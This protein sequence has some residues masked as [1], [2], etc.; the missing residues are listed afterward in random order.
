MFSIDSNYRFQYETRIVKAKNEMT[1]NLSNK[2]TGEGYGC[3]TRGFGGSSNIKKC[4][5][6]C[7]GDT[8]NI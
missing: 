6:G 4:G 1:R 3:A 8:S 2:D 5:F 7:G